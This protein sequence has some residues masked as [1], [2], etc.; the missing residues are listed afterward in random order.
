MLKNQTLDQ[1]KL[2]G[3]LFDM[4]ILLHVEEQN[5]KELI[6]SHIAKVESMI[7][8]ENIVPRYDDIAYQL[9]KVS[10]ILQ[11]SNEWRFL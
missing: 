9:F 1:Y 7:R 11:G 10:K 6:S 3:K 4:G 2:Y 5:S 8:E